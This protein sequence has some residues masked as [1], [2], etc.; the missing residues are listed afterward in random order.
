VIAYI[1][2]HGRTKAG[3]EVDALHSELYVV[4]HGQIV[5]RKGFHEADD[6]LV[7]AGLSARP[8]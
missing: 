8:A 3:I 1:R 2:E 4:K 7:E 6:A 5:H